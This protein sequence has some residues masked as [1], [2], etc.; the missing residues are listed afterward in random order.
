MIFKLKQLRYFFYLLAFFAFA[1]TSLDSFGYEDEFWSIDIVDEF[2]WASF[3]LIKEVDVHPPGAYVINWALIT[4]FK[5]WSLVRLW[6]S[7][8]LIIGVVIF[9]ERLVKRFGPGV[10]WVVLIFL[11]INPAFY[12]LCTGIR[13]YAYFVPLFLLG[14]WFTQ[15]FNRKDWIYYFV[16]IALLGYL[17]YLIF[18][19]GIPLTLYFYL[20]DQR[21]LKE[22]TVDLIYG[23]LVFLLIYGI[24]I[25]NFYVY[26]LF[27]TSGQV[28]SIQ[29]NALSFFT[30][31]FSNQG[32][33][34]L[35]V[36]GLLGALG[37]ALLMVYMVFNYQRLNYVLILSLVAIWSLYFM[38]GV[39]VKARNFV[40]ITGFF[41]L[42]IVHLFELKGRFRIFMFAAFGIIGISNLVGVWNVMSH[43]DSIKA[44]WNM[45]FKEIISHADSIASRDSNV[46]IL[47]HDPGISYTLMKKGHKVAGYY[48]LSKGLENINPSRILVY[49]TYYGGMMTQYRQEWDTLV[50]HLK[51]NQ[52]GVK[53][54]G[55]D[56]YADIKRKKDPQYP[57]YYCQ[58]I[59]CLNP[60][61]TW[62]SV[63]SW[64]NMSPTKVK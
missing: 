28:G 33:F 54:F 34:P 62:K 43:E 6:S 51:V 55:D 29:A 20:S 3:D 42:F 60:D 32:L 7:V 5:S 13:W 2:S 44:N 1:F 41:V 36:F 59:D 49:H 35:S 64:D 45:P 38:G 40:A 48:H 31:Y 53:I 21:N 56:K 14:P 63:L 27:D 23:G 15:H 30:F 9:S 50:D 47:S 19:I 46:I 22:K 25:K 26:H 18:V 12:L 24:E 37:F 52:G 61:S 58:F 17:N 11:L 8:F 10:F 57:D 39:G 16:W 4:V